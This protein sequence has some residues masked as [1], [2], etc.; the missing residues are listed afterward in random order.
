MKD[1]N[2]VE[3]VA[4]DNVK[5]L[6]HNSDL[7][8]GGIYKIMYI[9][10]GLKVKLCGV[11]DLINP[12]YLSKVEEHTLVEITQSEY[13]EFHEELALKDSIIGDLQDELEKL[14]G[15]VEGIVVGS[16]VVLREDSEWNN[17]DEANPL[18][19]AGEVV[20]IRVNKG[21]FPVK[22]KWENSRSN[23][24]HYRDLDLV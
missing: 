12:R 24:Y 13:D 18:G 14:R 16:R 20:L 2:G 5:Y 6:G 4:E 9:T 3:L 19:V 21:D 23:T 1:V 7:T 8:H 11:P 22:V 10:M 15:N 17:G